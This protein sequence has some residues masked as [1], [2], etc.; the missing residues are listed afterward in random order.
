MK[1]MLL[2]IRYHAFV[3]EMKPIGGGEIQTAISSFKILKY[4]YFCAF[5]Y[6]DVI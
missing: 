5:C 6:T 4:C 3:D 1:A 2:V